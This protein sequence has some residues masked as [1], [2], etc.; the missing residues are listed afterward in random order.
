MPLFSVPGRSLHRRGRR[1]VVR[2]HSDEDCQ[3]NERVSTRAESSLSRGQYTS[4]LEA[5]VAL[6]P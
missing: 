1:P 3:Y 4:K 5:V 6:P 2:T